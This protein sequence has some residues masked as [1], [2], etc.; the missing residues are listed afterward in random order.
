MV[1]AD[2]AAGEFAGDAS[3]ACERNN[4]RE[5]K[6]LKIRGASLAIRFLS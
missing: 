1:S 6:A 3:R 5:L 4:N 2:R